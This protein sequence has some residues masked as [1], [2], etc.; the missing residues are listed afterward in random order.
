MNALNS[1]L[2]NLLHVV[3]IDFAIQFDQNDIIYEGETKNSY[4][5]K[6]KQQSIL[7][8]TFERLDVQP[9]TNAFLAP[10][11]EQVFMPQLEPWHS[12]RGGTAAHTEVTFDRPVENGE[13]VFENDQFAQP[14]ARR[15]SQIVQ[16]SNKISGDRDQAMLDVKEK[17]QSQV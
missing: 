9:S 3:E 2:V 7:K 16:T 6:L 17:L 4:E 11:S 14:M 12:V 10:L 15:N 1:S 8:E 5:L 13:Q